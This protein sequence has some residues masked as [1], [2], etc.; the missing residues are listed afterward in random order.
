MRKIISENKLHSLIKN[1]LR[2]ALNE[3]RQSAV[4]EGKWTNRAAGVAFG[5]SSLFAGHNNA[6]AERAGMYPDYGS[7]IEQSIKNMKKAGYK[8]VHQSGSR[9]VGIGKDGKSMIYQPH[10]GYTQQDTIN[11]LVVKPQMMREINKLI[12]NKQININKFP[13]I[14]NPNIDGNMNLNYIYQVANKNGYSNDNF[15]IYY[16]EDRWYFLP[17]TN[18]INDLTGENQLDSLE[19]I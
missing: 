3:E 14:T 4:Q 17:N 6:Y 5:L 15:M 16:D 19:G 8:D 11:S 7:N 1:S 9:V 2:E 10:D 13:S 18:N 12:N